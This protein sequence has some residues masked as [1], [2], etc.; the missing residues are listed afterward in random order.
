M[1]RLLFFT[2]RKCRKIVLALNRE[3]EMS[4]HQI[5][6][7]FSGKLGVTSQ[8]LGNIL[9][10]TGIFDKSGKHKAFRLTSNSL[11]H[12]Y[13]ICKWSINYSNLIRKYGSEDTEPRRGAALYRYRHVIDTTTNEINSLSTMVKRDNWDF[14]HKEIK[15]I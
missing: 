6:D 4:T 1:H 11:D 10:K 14:I 2:G 7:L 15:G 12:S 8:E 5:I 9:S 13:T 3:G